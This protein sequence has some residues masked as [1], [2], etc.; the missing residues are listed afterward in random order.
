MAFRDESGRITIDELAAGQ[1]MANLRLVEESLTQ[2]AEHMLRL[3]GDAGDFSG[4]TGA[5][6]VDVGNQ[7]AGAARSS[8]ENARQLSQLIAAT[9]QKYRAIDQALKAAA[10]S[11]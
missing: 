9:V 11:L 7:F 5:A 6:I 8:A 10:E 2:V 1:D 4:N 3:A